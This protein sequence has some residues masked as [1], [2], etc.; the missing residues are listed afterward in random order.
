MP[1]NGVDYA[2]A[3]GTPVWAAASGSVAFV[4]PRGPNG[5]LVSL[6]H[7][8]GYETH[9]AHLL[10]VAPGLARGTE[11]RQRQVIGYVGSTGRSTGPHL[12]FGLQ[13]RGRFVDPQ[14]ELNG[15]GRMMPASQLGRFRR[16]VRELDAELDAIP[17]EA[18][19]DSEPE[20]SE[21]APVA[22]GEALD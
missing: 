20:P 21:P 19:A 1:H 2:A 8:G 18:P 13:H 12:H 4:G 7:E 10:R 3:P 14:A 6:T 15:P 9:Y 17:V 16:L 5:N 22:A 11:V